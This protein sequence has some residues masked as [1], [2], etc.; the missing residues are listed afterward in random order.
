MTT[1]RDFCRAIRERREAMSQPPPR[2]LP[3][4]K[5]MQFCSHVGMLYIHMDPQGF[6]LRVMH[7]HEL[8]GR[9]ANVYDLR[10]IGDEYVEAHSA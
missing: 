5:R 6:A 3:P 4:D 7:T 9:A 1:A 8:I 10:E 2:Q